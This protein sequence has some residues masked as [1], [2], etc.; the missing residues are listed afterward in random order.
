[1]PRNTTDAIVG[2]RIEDILDEIGMTKAELA[3]RSLD[4]NRSFLTRIIDNKRK[5]LSLPIAI[6]ISSVL[7]RPVEEV[8]IY[9]KSEKTE[10]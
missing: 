1:M 6:R 8:F 4:G 10:S 2:N 5:N 3:D 7:K 9:E